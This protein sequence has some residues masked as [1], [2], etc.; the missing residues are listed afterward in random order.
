MEKAEKLYQSALSE[1][2]AGIALQKMTQAA[3]LGH[4]N[5]LSYIKSKG[6]SVTTIN[7]KLHVY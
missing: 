3:E 7:G 2:I 4:A 1:K 6:L 5:A